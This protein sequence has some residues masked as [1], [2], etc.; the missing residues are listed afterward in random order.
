MDDRELSHLP[1]P[2]VL[3]AGAGI[4]VMPPAA[5][6]LWAEVAGDTIHRLLEAVQADRDDWDLS[7][8]YGSAARTLRRYPELLFEQ[9]RIT[10]GT[11][12]ILARLVD[13]LS[14]GKPNAC[15]R[16]IAELLERHGVRCAIIQL[17]DPFGRLGAAIRGFSGR[18]TK[19]ESPR[20]NQHCAHHH[21]GYAAFHCVPPFLA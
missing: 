19:R 5:A 15:H 4:S 21:T 6:P 9:I 3:F 18:Y 13:L 2:I 20:V 11:E 16:A 7:T 8:E 1:R 14:Q 12:Q 10:V 17:P